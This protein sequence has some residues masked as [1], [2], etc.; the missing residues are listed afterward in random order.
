MATI[1]L[2]ESSS[3]SSDESDKALSLCLRRAQLSGSKHLTKN[4]IPISL[5]NRKVPGLLTSQVIGQGSTTT[6]PTIRLLSLCN[7]V[8][9]HY[10]ISS[11]VAESE[12]ESESPGVGDFG[13][14]RNLKQLW[15]RSW[16]KCPTPK[17]I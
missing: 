8:S 13:W 7:F 5:N 11:R 6:N 4:Y 3:V 2:S 16:K 14:S 15:S 12:F 9:V 1:K 10:V 17:K